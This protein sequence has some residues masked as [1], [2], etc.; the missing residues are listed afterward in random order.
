INDKWII[1]N[2]NF[3]PESIVEVYNRWGE[4][5][6]RSN[7]GYTNPWDGTFNGSELP[8][9]TYYYVINLHDERFEPL[10]GPITIMR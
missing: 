8:V 6:F 7:P 2:I 5:L 1:D 9:G 4:M 3:F 10:T